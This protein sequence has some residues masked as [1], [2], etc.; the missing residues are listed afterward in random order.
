MKFHFRGGDMTGK[1]KWLW[2]IF[3][4]ICDKYF[5]VAVEYPGDKCPWW[6]NI[7]SEIEYR[8]RVKK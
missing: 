4:G 5:F 2:K 7:F 8:L 3:N 1:P 6:Y